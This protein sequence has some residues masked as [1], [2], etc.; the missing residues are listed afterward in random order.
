MQTK[1]LLEHVVLTCRECGEEFVPDIPNGRM[2]TSLW[3]SNILLDHS[4]E[5]ANAAFIVAV[6]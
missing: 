4:E 6:A 2:E 1:R 5:C 3:F